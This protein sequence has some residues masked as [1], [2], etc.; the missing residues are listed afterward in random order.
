MAF[1]TSSAWT[2]YCFCPF[3]VTVTSHIVVF[4]TNATWIL[5]FCPL[6]IVNELI[7]ISNGLFFQIS[8][9]RSIDIIKKMSFSGDYD[10]Y[11]IGQGKQHLSSQKKRKFE[12]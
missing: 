3:L 11:V 12:P 8:G 9:G 4:D 5:F 2:D 6:E 1:K 7:K 10:V